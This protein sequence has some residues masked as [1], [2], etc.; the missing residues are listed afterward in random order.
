MRKRMKP[1]PFLIDYDDKSGLAYYWLD[2]NIGRILLVVLFLWLGIW[3]LAL[4]GRDDLNRGRLFVRGMGPEL[5]G[6]VIGVVAI[7]FFNE[8]RQTQ[9]LKAQLIR[10]VGSNIRD[11]AVP[12]ARELAYHGWLYDGSLADTDLVE[13]DLSKADLTLANLSGAR[14]LGAN[15]SGAN[16]ER[17]N[18]SGAYL[19]GANLSG[20]DLTVTNLNGAYLWGA[21][22]S[23]AVMYHTDL[24]GVLEWTLEQLGEV[25]YQYSIMPDGVVVNL[26]KYTNEGL[27]FEVW[28]SKYLSKYGG[29]VFDHRNLSF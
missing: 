22:L 7:D 8:R 28:Q 14:L 20:A 3:G 16:L 23:G 29:T 13:A 15:L 5:A 1:H 27:S 6:I 2:E 12:A 25:D 19:W 18:L 17:A 21:N 9:Q 4:E 24:R 26:L 11:V 10:Q